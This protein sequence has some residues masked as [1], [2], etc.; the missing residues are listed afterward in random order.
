MHMSVLWSGTMQS[1]QGKLQQRQGRG[2]EPIY[3][4]V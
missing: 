2:G 1:S 4:A 3:V